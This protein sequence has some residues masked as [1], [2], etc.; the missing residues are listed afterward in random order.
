[1]RI[2]FALNT[3]RPHIDG[4]SIS[5]ERQAAGLAARGHTIAVIAPSPRL[6]SYVESGHSSRVYRVRTVAVDRHNRR[7]PIFPGGEIVR[8]LADFR[9]DV[10]VVSLPFLLSRAAW[11]AAIRLRYPV[12]GITSVMPEWF[13]YNFPVISA[14]ARRFDGSFWRFFVAY[15]NRCDH[16][17]GVS[18][19]AIGLLKRS[20]LKQPSTVISNGVPTFDFQPRVRDSAFGDR[21]GVP[22]KPTV[23]YAGRLDG[24]KCVDVIIRAIPRVLE[25]V[26]AH[27]IVGGEGKNRRSLEELVQRLGV[28][29]SVSFVGFLPDQEYPRLFS[30]ASTFAIASPAE[31]QSVVTLEAMAS[32]LPIVAA[33]AAALPELVRD[34]ENGLLFTPGDSN[35]LGNALVLILTNA[36][37]RTKLGVDSRRM[38]LDHDLEMSLDRYEQTYAMTVAARSEDARL[39]GA[40][41]QIAAM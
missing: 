17:V 28:A 21:L 11:S 34:G 7:F 24:D 8:S 22:D 27:F 41:S 14:L 16:V 1:M 33:N 2:L 25:R 31:L 18:N 37:M 15:Y 29:N 12:V 40:A 4:V 5:L 32:G 23:L 3:A 35:A 9:P 39:L 36:E 13:Y 20:G 19:T 6:T 38:A 30:L 10:V 26:D